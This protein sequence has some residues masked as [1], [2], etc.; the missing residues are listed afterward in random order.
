[1]QT[2]V[3]DQPKASKRA[4]ARADQRQRLA[5]LLVRTGQGDRA[6]FR[7]VYD[8]SI[9]YILCVVRSVLNDAEQGAEVAQDVYVAIWRRAAE[10]DPAKGCALKWMAAIARNRAIDRFRAERTRSFVRFE[11]ETPDQPD[12]TNVERLALDAV[13]ARRLLA[14]LKPEY[15]V[16]LT[17][18][19]VNGYSHSELAKA[20]GVPLGT[21]KSWVRRG[22]SQLQEAV[23]EPATDAGF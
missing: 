19:Y 6:A 1:M 12:E 21:A 15:R 17:L 13:A 7:Q 8:D 11:A 22:L 3:M 4:S 9:R 18:A 10:Y 5:E 14:S 20:M 2:A 16:S 23:A